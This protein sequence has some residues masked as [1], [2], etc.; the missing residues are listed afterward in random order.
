MMGVRAVCRSFGQIPLRSRCL[1]PKSTRIAC[2]FLQT[3][4]SPVISRNQSERAASIGGIR[5]TSTNST[6]ASQHSNTPQRIYKSSLRQRPL[7]QPTSIFHYHFP[8]AEEPGSNPEYP[9]H[10]PAYIDGIS[11]KKLSR[12]EVRKSAL[13]LGYSLIHGQTQNP[14]PA[15]TPGD[16]IFILSPNSLH[17]PI[18][19]FA[20]QSALL[21][22]TLCNSSATS[23]DVAYQLKDSGAKLA[24]VHPDLVEVWEGAMEILLKEEYGW[25]EDVE[26]FEHIMFRKEIPDLPEMFLLASTDEAKSLLHDSYEILLPMEG[27]SWG[28]SMA[29]WKGLQVKEA[30]HSSAETYEPVSYDDTAVICYSS[31]TTGLPKGKNTHPLPASFM[32]L[33]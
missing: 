22:P 10:L 1:A 28:K 24:F 4:Y 30:P 21:V 31:G 19:F 11:A 12:K 3:G 29:S 26:P 23:R 14:W 32:L 7:P 25:D 13:A 17:Y 2:P 20:C 33:I 5:W 18:I 27:E 15:A 6:N 8:A 9:D 16:V